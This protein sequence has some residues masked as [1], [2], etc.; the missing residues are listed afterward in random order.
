MAEKCTP[1]NLTANSSG[2]THKQITDIYNIVVQC[3]RLDCL[4]RTQHVSVS[5]MNSSEAEQKAI[6]EV[7]SSCPNNF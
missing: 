7:C 3:S 2:R 6:K 5:A 4:H 1:D